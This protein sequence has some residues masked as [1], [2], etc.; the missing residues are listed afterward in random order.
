MG[1]DEVQEENNEW[2]FKRN[3][4]ALACITGLLRL[5]LE[6]FHVQNDL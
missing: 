1:P 5:F 4:D 6:H 3:Q 2:Q